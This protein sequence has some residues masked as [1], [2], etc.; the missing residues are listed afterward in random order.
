MADCA[1]NCLRMYDDPETNEIIVC[2]M[3][4]YWRLKSVIVSD[5]SKS[6]IPYGVLQSVYS[7]HFQV[8]GY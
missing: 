8:T 7:D 3:K 4:N 6:L 1:D 2:A 5:Q